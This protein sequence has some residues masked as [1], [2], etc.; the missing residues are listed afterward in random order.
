MAPLPCGALDM[1]G[2]V[3]EWTRSLND[4][5]D[6]IDEEF[7]VYVYPYDP[8]DA[9]REALE[10]PQNLSRVVRE[11]LSRVVRGGLY[12]SGPR[13]TDFRSSAIPGD[14]KGQLGFR[15]VFARPRFDPP[16]HHSG[17]CQNGLDGPAITCASDRRFCAKKRAR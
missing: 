1:S 4:V 11:N 10:V 2:N 16:S 14:G 5:W 7:Q 3:W 13:S 15:V 9:A 12:A 8:Q 17:N 6:E